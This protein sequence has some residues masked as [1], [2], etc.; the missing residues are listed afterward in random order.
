LQFLGDEKRFHTAWVKRIGLTTRR[1]L[2][3]LTYEQTLAA[4]V[5]MSQ[6]CHHQ[7]VDTDEAKP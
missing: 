4:S 1:S 3:V 5:G 7:T 2:L 6:R